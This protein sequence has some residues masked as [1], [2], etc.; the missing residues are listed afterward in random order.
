MSAVARSR[1]RQGTISENQRQDVDECC[2]KEQDHTRNQALKD[3]PRQRAALLKIK[4][5][6]MV[7][8]NF[9]IKF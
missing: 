2:S 5:T 8:Y 1:R 4:L 6:R 3:A 7:F 9:M